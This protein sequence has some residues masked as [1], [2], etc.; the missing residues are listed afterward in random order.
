M[1]K[2][3]SFA[4][5]SRAPYIRE[6][7]E[8]A[9]KIGLAADDATFCVDFLI[10]RRSRLMRLIKKYRAEFVNAPLELNEAN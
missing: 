9:K 10:K 7:V 4:S 8:D 6:T 1:S 2:D 5:L 3:F